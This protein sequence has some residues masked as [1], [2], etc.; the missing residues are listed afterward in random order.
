MVWC[1]PKQWNK[2]LQLFY[3]VATWCMI[4]LLHITYFFVLFK[5]KLNGAPLTQ[6]FWYFETSSLLRRVDHHGNVCCK[7]NLS[8]SSDHQTKTCSPKGPV[9]PALHFTNQI[10]WF[11][12][13]MNR[14]KIDKFSQELIIKKQVMKSNDVRWLGES[15][16]KVNSLQNIGPSVSGRF[17]GCER[18]CT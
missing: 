4:L 10:F 13:A 9:S 2:A 16:T 5:R 3:T 8:F 12:R 17:G 14:F 7:T 11:K 18:G 15:W 1:L 6:L